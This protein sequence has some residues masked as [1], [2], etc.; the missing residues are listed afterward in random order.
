[1]PAEQNFILLK[2]CHFKTKT[3]LMEALLIKRLEPSSNTKLGHSEGAKSLLHV[4]Q[5]ENVTNLVNSVQ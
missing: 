3:E 2:K 1:M 4:V 5:C